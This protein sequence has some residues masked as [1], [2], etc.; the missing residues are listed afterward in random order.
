MGAAEEWNQLVGPWR[1]EAERRGF[2]FLKRTVELIAGGHRCVDYLS[3]GATYLDL[4]GELGATR[5]LWSGTLITWID[6]G[7]SRFSLTTIG[8]AEPRP[9][10]RGAAGWLAARVVGPLMQRLVPP[11]DRPV[12]LRA[13]GDLQH[14][15][16]K[17]L[18]EVL[19]IAGKPV[20]FESL[21]D[22][23]TQARRDGGS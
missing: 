2:R 22:R 5:G 12:R 18:G 21:E 9:R 19:A 1:S 3:S 17:H 8:A 15:I 23:F 14:A 6:S 7:D 11:D 16:E 10:P 4:A 13:P 20:R